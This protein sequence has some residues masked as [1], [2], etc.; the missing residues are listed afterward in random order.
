MKKRGNP[1][2]GRRLRE[3]RERLGMSQDQMSED[4]GIPRSTIGGI[5][6]ANRPAGREILE[7]LSKYFSVPLDYFMNPDDAMSAA[8]WILGRLSKD[9]LDA[10]V[11]LMMMR[12]DI[13]KRP[14]QN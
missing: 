13:Q 14:P 2:I 3:A 4:S 10:W 9:E 11:R 1:L 12:A 7:K 8:Q 6:S 5:E